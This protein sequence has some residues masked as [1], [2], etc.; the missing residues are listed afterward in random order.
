MSSVQCRNRD[1]QSVRW[2]LL[3]ILLFGHV[4]ATRLATTPRRVCTTWDILVVNSAIQV[5]Q[6]AFTRSERKGSSVMQV[7][8]KGMYSTYHASVF[9]VIAKL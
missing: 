3:C 6:G 8:V 1:L 4:S 9:G 2:M 5:K 7:R